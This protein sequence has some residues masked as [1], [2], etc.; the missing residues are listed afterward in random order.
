VVTRLGSV[1]QVTTGTIEG[2][3]ASDLAFLQ[4]FYGVIN[5]GSQAEYEELL[6]AQRDAD[7]PVTTSVVAPEQS[8]APVAAPEGA[9]AG[10]SPATV[11][12]SRP[13]RSAIE[14]IPHDG[15]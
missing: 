15:R 2:L 7:A 12:Y 8:V 14:E 3:F 9:P 10:G 13:L 11:S 1:P 5:F 4:D 6:A